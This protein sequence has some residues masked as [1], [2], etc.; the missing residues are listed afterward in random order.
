ML[1]LMVGAQVADAQLTNNSGSDDWWVNIESSPVRIDRSHKGDLLLFA[2][3]SSKR[4]LQVQVG[5]IMTNENQLKI[6]KRGKL[7]KIDL[8]PIDSA[9]NVS[10][11]ILGS[12][13]R[14]CD[15]CRKSKLSVIKVKFAD[16]SSWH[17]WKE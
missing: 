5:C 9:G 4:V 16:A 12:Y 17:L 14:Y 2:N 15:Y 1:S 3:Y 8:S 11:Q 13:D 10:L 7:D 6:K